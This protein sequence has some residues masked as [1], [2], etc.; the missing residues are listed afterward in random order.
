MVK[1]LL[2]ALIF[3]GIA[4]FRPWKKEFHTPRSLQEVATQ[5]FSEVMDKPL[6]AALIF[7]GNI[8]FHPWKK[9]FHTPRFLQEG[10]TQCFSEVMVKL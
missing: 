9:E 4:G 3:M 8:A 6:L 7:M 10:I 2:A 5:C 1:L